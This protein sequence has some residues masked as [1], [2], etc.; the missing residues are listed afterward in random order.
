MTFVCT[1]WESPRVES[2]L[3]ILIV[4]VRFGRLVTLLFRVYF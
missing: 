4:L 1:Q 2:V 3:M